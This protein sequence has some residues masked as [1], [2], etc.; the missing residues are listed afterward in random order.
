MTKGPFSTYVPTEK[1][2]DALN[3]IPGVPTEVKRR[4][5]ANLEAADVF[6]EDN[7]RL[8]YLG[9]TMGAMVLSVGTLQDMFRLLE[10]LYELDQ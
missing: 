5:I 8:L 10:S 2:K 1:I 7:T 4:V 9:A 6:K 3:N